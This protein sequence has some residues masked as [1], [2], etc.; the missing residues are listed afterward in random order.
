MVGEQPARQNRLMPIHLSRIRVVPLAAALVAFTC[1]SA[2]IA[3]ADNWPSRTVHVIVP[4]PAGGPTDAQARW[5]AQKLSDALGQPFIVENR[6]AAGGAPGTLSVVKSPPD[7]YTLLVANPGPLTVGPQLKPAKGYTHK[8]LAPV[9][10]IAK[11]PSCL[12]VRSA[13]PAKTFGELVSQ[14]RTAPGRVTYGSPGVGTAGHLM[15]ELISAQAKVK[16][17]HIPYRGAAQV[18]N[19]LAAGTI[20]LSVMQVGTCSALSRQGKVRALAVT[21]RNRA[22][23]LPD[24][25]TLA[26]SGLAGFD[27]SNWNGLLAPAATPPTILKK[28]TDVLSRELATPETRK[29]LGETGYQPSGETGTDFAAFLQAESERWGRVIQDANISEGE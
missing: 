14:A 20:D 22:P 26:E 23:Q 12:A 10:L 7:G 1:S 19:D 17:N 16:F 24:V 4:F 18:S 5:A 13:L 29:W 6:S 28:I 15:T 3:Q 9:L 8:D 21:S 25:P 11:T 2:A 27:V